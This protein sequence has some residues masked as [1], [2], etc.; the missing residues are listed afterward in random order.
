[1]KAAIP[2]MRDQ[3]RAHV[4]WIEAQLGDGREWLLGEFSLAD[5]NA[6]MNVWYNQGAPSQRS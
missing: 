3:F 2:Q 4:G 1:M 6:H 5:I